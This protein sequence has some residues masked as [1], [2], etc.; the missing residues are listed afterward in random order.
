M[1]NCVFIF[2]I[3]ALV[4]SEILGGPKFK[5]GRPVPPCTPLEENVVPETST[6][7]CLMTFLIS[8]LQLL[9]F[10]RYQGV[11]NLH[12]GAALRPLDAPSGEI[13]VPKASMSQYL[14]VF[15]ISTIQ[16][17]YFPGYQGVPNL[18]QGALRSPEAP[19]RKNFDMRASTCLYLYN[20][21]FSAS[22]LHSRWTNGAL[23]LQQVLH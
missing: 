12:Q 10:S 19:Q 11:P 18:H 17:Q 21:K 9:Y 20:C 15:V 4:R 3:L 2:N 1:S 8:I 14:I 13:F 16:L 6:L 23:S 7:L 22:Q 5:L